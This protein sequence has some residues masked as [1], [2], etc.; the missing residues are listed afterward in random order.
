MPDGLI[1]QAEEEGVKLVFLW[2][3]L[4][5]NGMSTYVPDSVKQ[6]RGTYFF[7]RD[8]WGK[9]VNA[10]SPLCQAGVERDA[11][12]FTAL[13]SHLKEF[14]VNRTV[15]MVQV[16]NEMGLLAI[17]AT[18]ALRQKRLIA[19]AVPTDAAVSAG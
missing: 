11:A 1:Q 5:K 3:G 13:M 6:D 2:F 8:R 14:D 15:L 10:V 12:A 18:S 4:W 16:E 19:E 17:A 7:M 9:P